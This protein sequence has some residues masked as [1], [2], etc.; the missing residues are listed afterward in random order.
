MRTPGLVKIFPNTA[1]HLADLLRLAEVGHGI[2]E[3]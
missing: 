2:V 3:S 1:E